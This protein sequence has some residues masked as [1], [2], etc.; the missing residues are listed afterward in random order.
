MEKPNCR[1]AL[2]GNSHTEIADLSYFVTVSRPN[3]VIGRDFVGFRWLSDCGLPDI[4]LKTHPSTCSGNST[5]SFVRDGQN[6]D[7]KINALKS[8]SASLSCF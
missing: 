7:D 8:I 5:A 3:S 4:Y 1:V 6:A 2:T